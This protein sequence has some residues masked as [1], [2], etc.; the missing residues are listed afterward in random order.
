MSVWWS[1]HFISVSTWYYGLRA[2]RIFIVIF[3]DRSSFIPDSIYIVFSYTK[4]NTFSNEAEGTQATVPHHRVNS[5]GTRMIT[6][7]PIFDRRRRVTKNPCKVEK[8]IC[9]HTDRSGIVPA[10][11]GQLAKGRD[12]QQNSISLFFLCDNLRGSCYRRCG[13]NLQLFPAIICNTEPT[14][15]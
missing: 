11:R 13:N 10:G 12:S 6:I 15:S 2:N 8:K 3:T 9:G 14:C 7:P 5:Y 1:R 4:K